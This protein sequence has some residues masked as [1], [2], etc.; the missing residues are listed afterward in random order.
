MADIN[1]EIL[2]KVGVLSGPLR[3]RHL[4][5]IRRGKRAVGILSSVV[6]FGGRVPGV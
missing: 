1:Y 3:L 6:G 4:P 5:Q 2:E